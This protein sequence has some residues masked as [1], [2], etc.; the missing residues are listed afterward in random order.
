MRTLLAAAFVVL[1]GQPVLADDVLVARRANTFS[2]NLPGVPTRNGYDE[3][4]TRDGTFCRSSVGGSG[5]YLDMGALASDTGSGRM[6]NAGVY[7]RVVVPLGR[8]PKRIDCTG[9]YTL[10]IERL[11]AEI[12]MMRMGR[13]QAVAGDAWAKDGWS[14]N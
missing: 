12:E 14:R 10:E 4:R 8:K 7:G 2:A 11:R 1:G 5:A 6:D 3:I 13:T 9:L